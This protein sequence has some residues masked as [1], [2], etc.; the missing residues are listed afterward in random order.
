MRVDEVGLPAASSERREHQWTLIRRIA[1]PML[2]G[3]KRWLRR[4]TTAVEEEAAG[5]RTVAT[6]GAG[7]DAETSTNAQVE[8]ASG[9]PWPGRDPRS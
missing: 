3:L 1:L 9:R 6:P 2:D 4:A 8:G 7:V 5:E